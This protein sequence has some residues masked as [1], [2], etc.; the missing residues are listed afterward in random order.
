VNYLSVDELV[1]IHEAVI[2]QSGGSAGI[3]DMGALES[4]A[5]QP[6]GGFGDAEFY[7]TLAE[8]A[9]ALCYAIIKN[10]PCVDGNKRLGSAAMKVFLLRNSFTIDADIDDRERVILSVA[11]GTMGREQFT[12]WLRAH[13]VPAAPEGP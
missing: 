11:A 1:R 10:H 2:A 3:R 13:I 7:P 12:E 5:A 6:G 4:A 9:A 8:K